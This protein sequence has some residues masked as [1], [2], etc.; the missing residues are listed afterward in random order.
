MGLKKKSK[1]AKNN[2]NNNNDVI[3]FY[4]TKAVKELNNH[5][6]NPTEKNTGIDYGSRVLVGEKQTLCVTS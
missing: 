4:E 5:L 3:N 2:N 6:K 1:V